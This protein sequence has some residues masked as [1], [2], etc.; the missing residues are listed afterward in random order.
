MT[1]CHN[2]NYHLKLLYATEKNKFP[3]R[4]N[5]YNKLIRSLTTVIFQSLAIYRWLLFY[6]S[7]LKAFIIN[8]RQKSFIFKKFMERTLIKTLEYR[9]LVTKT[10][11]LNLVS[12][13]KLVGKL[14]GPFLFFR[15]IFGCI[16]SSAAP[17]GVFATASRLPVTGA[18]PA[19]DAGLR[20]SRPQQLPR[21]AL[22]PRGVGSAARHPVGPQSPPRE[23][24]GVAALEGGHQGSP[25]TG[26]ENC[27]SETK[28]S[29]NELD[30]ATRALRMITVLM[31]FCLRHCWS[32]HCA[33]QAHYFSLSLKLLAFSNL[34]N[35]TFVNRTE[36]FIFSPNLFPLKLRLLLNILFSWKYSYL[37]EVSRICSPI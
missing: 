30:G 11:P 17:G 32:F 7:F 28:E 15:F 10:T 3:Y 1:V 24:T 37:Y 23:G 29:G 21:E 35:Y 20:A 26:S 8:C 4:H 14:M 36:T 13:S 5:F 2:S 9:Y 25:L 6:W 16:G 34:E 33:F 18:S 27:W 31:A 22:E 12:L 19:V